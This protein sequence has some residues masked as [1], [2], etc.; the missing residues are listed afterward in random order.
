MT[1]EEE[2][3]KKLDE[4][5]GIGVCTLIDRPKF[6]RCRGYLIRWFNG[7]EKKT[8][9]FPKDGPPSEILRKK[10]ERFK[11]TIEAARKVNTG[12]K[13]GFRNKEKTIARLKEAL[14]EKVEVLS[15]FHT[16]K[17]NKTIVMAEV[18]WKETGEISQHNADSLMNGLK[19]FPP[20][21]VQKKKEETSIERYGYKN[22][23]MN[24]DI[25]LKAAK[26]TNKT[27]EIR[28]WKTNEILLCQ[29]LYE[30]V[31][32]EYLNKSNI[33]Y[34][35]Q[36]TYELDNGKTYAVDFVAD[37]IPIEVKG[38]WYDEEA[39]DKWKSFCLLYPSAQLWDM[40][41]LKKMGLYKRY[42]QLWK[43]S[44]NDKQTNASGTS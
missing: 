18:L 6:G 35:F 12:R 8:R 1:K 33:D 19:R 39:R 17:E 23:T 25:R 32:A 13:I 24:R 44:K 9:E 11:K 40:A 7:E 37:S 21:L 36:V 16:R 4:K 29:G 15:I 22:P 34:D 31:V 38:Y 3:Q 27:Y 30:F 28:H 26:S 20:S 2:I 41:Y 10:K 5:F 14:E 43:A 42:L